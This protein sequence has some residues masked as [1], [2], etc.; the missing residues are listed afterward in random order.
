[1]SRRRIW[2]HGYNS[3]QPNWYFYLLPY[4]GGDEYGRRTLTIPIHPA[5][6]FTIAYWTCKCE[7]CDAMRAQTERWERGDYGS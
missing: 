6:F 4:R 5:G 1:M 3:W 2:Y 7:E